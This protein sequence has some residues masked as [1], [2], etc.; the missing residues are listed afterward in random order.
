MK[1]MYLSI[2]FTLLST[3]RKLFDLLRPLL[4][5]TLLFSYSLS[6]VRTVFPFCE[7]PSLLSHRSCFP[8]SGKTRTSIY[9]F[10]T[11]DIREA[12]KKSSLNC[13]VIKRGE[14]G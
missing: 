14:G 8:P 7:F 11:Q 13:R 5:T 6:K 12:T 3:R 10:L 4:K 1:N 9:D 2:I